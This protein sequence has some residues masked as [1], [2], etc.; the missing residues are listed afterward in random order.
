[1]PAPIANAVCGPQKPD[2]PTPPKGTNITE[3]NPCPLNTCCNIVSFTFYVFPLSI[4]KDSRL[5]FK[6]RS[7][8]SV[9]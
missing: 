4:R 9:V 2:T 6:Q 3:L 8:V 5:T 1:M 7:G